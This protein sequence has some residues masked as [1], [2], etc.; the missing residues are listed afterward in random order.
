LLFINLSVFS[1]VNNIDSLKAWADKLS[2]SV[3]CAP[4]NGIDYVQLALDKINED[5]LFI[6]FRSGISS[7]LNKTAREILKREYSLIDETPGEGCVIPYSI[8]CFENLMTKAIEYKFGNGFLD[9]IATHS[10]YLDKSGLGYIP[11]KFKND[12]LSIY[13][14]LKTQNYKPINFEEHRYFDHLNFLI[15]KKGEVQNLTFFKSW[16]FYPEKNI[17][18]SK[19]LTKAIDKGFFWEAAYLKGEPIL[20]VYDLLL[21]EW[22]FKTN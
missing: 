17:N 15:N 20:E 5:S 3:G 10:K 22:N 13:Q 19:E 11:P 9:S 7:K 8:W 14:F 4:E 16:P 2:Q 1:Q 6:P 18:V 21:A 12:S